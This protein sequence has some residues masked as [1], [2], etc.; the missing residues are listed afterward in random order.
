MCKVLP[1]VDVLGTFTSADNVIVPFNARGFVLVHR[2]R[3]SR[4]RRYRISHPVADA[5]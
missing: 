5:E 4:A 3:R 2:G 1:D